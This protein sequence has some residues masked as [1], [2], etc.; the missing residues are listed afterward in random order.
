MLRAFARNSLDELKNAINQ[1]DTI[2]VISEFSNG[3]KV[4][5]GAKA[6]LKVLEALAKDKMYS[7][8]VKAQEKQNL[9][10]LS[11]I[12]RIKQ[13]KNPNAPKT[14]SEEYITYRLKQAKID[15]NFKEL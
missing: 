4:K 5:G 15:A 3:N 10:Q 13:K 12:E 2:D 7:A 14:N 6:G 11:P 1:L 9:K 8:S